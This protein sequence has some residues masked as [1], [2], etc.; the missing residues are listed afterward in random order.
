MTVYAYFD[1][2]PLPV[3]PAIT[4]A[5]QHSH[6]QFS[7]GEGQHDRAMAM[8]RGSFL[9]QL[10]GRRA[11]GGGGSVVGS[12]GSLR[13]QLVRILSNDRKD[14]PASPIPPVEGSQVGGGA[15][16][17]VPQAPTTTTTLGK[18]VVVV[19]DNGPGISAENQKRLFKEVHRC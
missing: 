16:P 2:E 12:R 19:A 18:L 3:A 11:N 9:D 14:S 7:V 8:R 15:S 13:R 4:V 17:V 10:T 5:A 1:A 6:N